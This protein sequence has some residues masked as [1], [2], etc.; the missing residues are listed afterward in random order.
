MSTSL[1]LPILY[2]RSSLRANVDFCEMQAYLNYILGVERKA[3]LKAELGTVT[4]AVLECLALAKLGFQNSKDKKITIKHPAIGVLEVDADEWLKAEPLTETEIAQINLTRINKDVYK[5]D[6]SLKAGTIYQGKKFVDNL[7]A[8]CSM[9]YSSKSEFTWAPIDF[10]KV[11]NWVWIVL[12]YKNGLYDPRKQE[13]LQPEQNFDFE[14]EQE[15]AKYKYTLP[16]GKVLE[17]KLALKG[18]IDLTVVDRE[19]ETVEIVDYK[20]GQR[21]DWASGEVKSYAKLQQDKQLMLYYYAAQKLYPWAKSII[22][23]IFF[24]RDGG[25]FSICFEPHQLKGIEQDIRNTFEKIQN[26]TVPKMCDPTQKDF[27]CRLLCDYYKMK[28]DGTN[29]CKAIHERLKTQ[30][31]EQVMKD[32]MQIDKLGVYQAPGE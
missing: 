2:I 10:K 31:Q 26:W 27:K 8:L 22:L 18:T 23:T 11:R 14:I 15:W 24:I 7:I 19:H 32:F 20:S 28:L 17:G 5:Y 4:H 13:I 6:C 9:Y 16:N 21:L 29:F 30:G 25:P 3:G 12:E 1:K